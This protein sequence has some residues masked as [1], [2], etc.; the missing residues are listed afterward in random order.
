GANIGFY[1][2]L[3]SRWVGPAG[4]VLAYEPDPENVRL[5]EKN[6]VENRCA[7]TT[8]RPVA[9]GRECGSC[10]FSRDTVTGLTG[11][12]GAGTTY[13]EVRF[14]TGKEISIG[15]P[16]RTLDAEIEMAGVVPGVVKL[17]T[18][19]GEYDILCGSV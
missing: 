19:G 5:L 1:S 17:D 11:H 18:E 13:G 2:V 6:V 12:V 14:R 10:L 4:R 16:L 8:V 9:L 3:F 15:V 7:G